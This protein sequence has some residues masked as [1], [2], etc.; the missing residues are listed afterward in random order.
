MENTEFCMNAQ[1]SL[2]EED[3]AK[4]GLHAGNFD[5]R[6]RALSSF[7]SCPD[8]QKFF[9]NR[10]MT[11]VRRWNMTGEMKKVEYKEMVDGK[12]VK[13]DRMVEERTPI[14]GWCFNTPVF[15][16]DDH[17]DFGSWTPTGQGSSLV[18]VKC[19]D[20]ERDKRIEEILKRRSGEVKVEETKEDPKKMEEHAEPG[21]VMVHMAV[22]LDDILQAS[23][24]ALLQSLLFD[25]LLKATGT[26]PNR[27][28]NETTI[29]IELRHT[30]NS[31]LRRRKKV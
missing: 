7:R 23:S 21:K 5:G 1:R 17:S 31:Y 14:D 2:A 4:L 26:L 16:K 11:K 22:P 12:E 28:I 19:M 27:D 25:A 9:Q 24:S 10:C 15:M 18:C 13:T 29:G 8:N 30:I 3:Y 6:E 20:R